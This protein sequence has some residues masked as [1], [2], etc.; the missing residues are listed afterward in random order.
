V[1]S[2]GLEISVFTDEMITPRL[3]AE[4]QR[5][6]YDVESCRDAGRANLSI[7]DEDQLAYATNAGRAICTFNYPDFAALDALWHARGRSHAG[8]IVSVDLDSEQTEMAR[9]LQRH[10]DTVD[11]ATQR[12]RVMILWP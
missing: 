8:I 10:L 7:S 11:A 5:R 12:D 6:G 2:V 1:T 3:A 4:M 9:R